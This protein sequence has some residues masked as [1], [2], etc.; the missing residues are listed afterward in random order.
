MKG[1]LI[2]L[3]FL[4]LAVSGVITGYVLFNTFYG[5]KYEK[6]LFNIRVL[7]IGSDVIEAFKAYLGLSLTYSSQQAL[8]ESACFGGL[9][10]EQ[11]WAWICNSP[12]PLPVEKSK[13]C[14]EKFIKYYL[15]VYASNFSIILPLSLIHI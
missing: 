5:T 6:E 12:N 1:Q 14:S 4:I 10:S 8:R 13:E 9:I 11:P 15:N 2:P 7:N 3:V